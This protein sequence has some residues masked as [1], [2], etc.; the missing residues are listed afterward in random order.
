M[1][2]LAKKVGSDWQHL[3]RLA[4][5]DVREPKFMVGIKILDIHYDLMS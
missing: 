3:N 2:Q 4:R 5:G 1:S